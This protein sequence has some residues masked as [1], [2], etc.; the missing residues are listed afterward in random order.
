MADFDE[1]HL[2]VQPNIQ[3]PGAWSVFLDKCRV[4]APGSLGDVQPQ[5]TRDQLNSLRNRHNFPDQNR[6]IAI[7]QS[8]A[9]SLMTP[10]L[11][12][13]LQANLDVS[14]ALGRGI[15]LV[16]AMVGEE[17]APPVDAG[18]A[19]PPG[20][21]PAPGA[22]PVRLQELPLEAL[23]FGNH[24]LG[25]DPMSP[26]SRSLEI[27]ERDPVHVT[28]PL[29]V[30]VVV[31][32][33]TGV[34]QAQIAE[35]KKVIED[36]FDKL[37]GPGGAF[38]LEFCDP[39]TKSEL[40]ARLA[41]GF[42]ILHFAGHGA[43]DTVGNDP[44]PRPH[45]VL[46][47]DGEEDPI[48]A[49]TL[50]SVLIS[51]GI[52][53]V[54]LTACSSAAPAPEEVEGTVGPFCGMAQK[55]VSGM[56]GVNAAVAMQLD[57]ASDAAVQFSK[58]FYTQLLTSN[59]KL[60]EIVALCRQALSAPKGVGDRAWVT[61]VIYWRC[62]DGRVFEIEP[63]RG[64]FDE[65]TRI[66]L[67]TLQGKIQENLDRIKDLQSQPPNVLNALT[68]LIAG[69]QQKI[70]DLILRR[71]Q[72]MG[73]T[74]RLRGGKAAPGG[75]VAC[76]LLL[77]LRT[78]ALV[79]S[80]SCRLGYPANQM[81]FSAAAPGA[82]IPGAPPFLDTQTAGIV[83]VQ[84]NNIP[85]GAPW[86][87]GEYELATISFQVNPGV[88]DPYLTLSLADAN[89]QKDGAGVIFNTLDGVVFVT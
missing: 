8:V 34:T 28:L 1:F 37:A 40:V 32:R 29:R 5:F 21:G 68:G 7:G 22:Q 67:S 66:E 85:Q 60:D 18:P 45:L 75:V 41:N 79:G 55:L 78:P 54:V 38:H 43:Y 19:P 23:R 82:A 17:P 57:L 77:R 59:R 83:K 51:S 36:A 73:E 58:T 80:A 31:A 48:D 46:E 52:R 72:L 15:R 47:K 74:L 86:M 35:E 16:V 63:M 53:L 30:L 20:V 88:T 61:P 33:P 71:G 26:L 84:F 64:V 9:D 12:L 24:F 65:P 14:T 39:P 62:R 6:L 50:D 81:G 11:Q 42:H 2:I 4:G 27:D 69:W 56:S 49:E 3:N 10:G 76:Q 13:A 87:P 44:S 70:D 25:L 89:V